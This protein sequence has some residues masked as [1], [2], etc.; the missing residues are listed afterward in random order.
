MST[1]K[2][3]KSE[4]TATVTDIE[5]PRDKSIGKIHNVLETEGGLEIEAEFDDPLKFFDVIV[6]GKSVGTLWNLKRTDTGFTGDFYPADPPPLT[7][8]QI[9]AAFDVPPEMMGPEP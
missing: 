1:I 3:G 6:D 9:A 7:R 8:E 4:F 2:F 5:F